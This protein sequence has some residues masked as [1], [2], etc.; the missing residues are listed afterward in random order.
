M[1]PRAAPVVALTANALEGDRNACVAAGMDDFLA[2]P[3]QLDALRG[4]PRA[5][6]AGHPVPRPIAALPLATSATGTGPP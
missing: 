1:A 5:S 4:I 2:K 6:V 3:M